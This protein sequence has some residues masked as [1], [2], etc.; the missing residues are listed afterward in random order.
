MSELTLVFDQPS[1][2]EKAR[3]LRIFIID[4]V[5][6]YNLELADRLIESLTNEG[7]L[8]SIM[9]E[10]MAAYTIDNARKLNYQ[11]NEL[12]RATVKSD[13]GVD[14]LVANNGLTRAVIGV[15]DNK[16][17]LESNDSLLTRFDLSHFQAN[18]TGTRHGYKFHALS[19]GIDE[20]PAITVKK[21]D[22]KII[23]TFTYSSFNISG[24]SDCEF[25]SVESGSG[26]VIGAATP[27]KGKA[28]DL[29]AWL[30][31]MQR[32]DIAQE[33]DIVSVKLATPMP[34]SVSVTAYTNNDPA[35][36]VD[37]EALLAEC[38]MLVDGKRHNTAR[39]SDHDFSYI[40]KRLG[41]FDVEITGLDNPLVCEWDEYPEIQELTVNVM[42]KRPT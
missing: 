9:I 37:Q 41:A 34:Y 38:L 15:V 33:T 18:T 10:A 25:R 4:Y 17:V 35:Y 29:V 7:E 6:A 40:A 28:V 3:E 39:V 5:A 23:Q 31:Y 42:G 14:R 16:P 32:P 24:I 21:E 12:S 22:N 2:E 27:V 1:F 30:A 13:H 8:L 20:R 19:Y 26:K 36:H 11:A